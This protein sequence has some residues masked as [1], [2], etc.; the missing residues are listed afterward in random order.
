MTLLDD[1][2]KLPVD[3][4]SFSFTKFVQAYIQD[5][6][7]WQRILVPITKPFLVKINQADTQDSLGMFRMILRFV[8]ANEFDARR[9]KL[10]ADYICQKGLM[11]IKLRDEILNK[12]NLDINS[13]LNEDFSKD[14]FDILIKEIKN[15]INKIS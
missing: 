10:L 6:E 4:N 2:N 11:N 15:T 9:D 12:A 7:S 8:N 1:T 3:I 14:Q 5:F 13:W